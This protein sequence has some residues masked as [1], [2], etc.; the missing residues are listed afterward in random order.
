MWFARLIWA[1]ILTYIVLECS[2]IGTLKVMG[3]EVNNSS[4]HCGQSQERTVSSLP[5]KL[6]H[7]PV[8]LSLPYYPWSYYY[9]QVRNDPDM[10]PYLDQKMIPALEAPG[11][12]VYR[13]KQMAAAAMC[14]RL[15]LARSGREAD[16]A[17]DGLDP[18][19]TDLRVAFAIALSMEIAKSEQSSKS[20]RIAALRE[21]LEVV[22]ADYPVG[23]PKPF[24]FAAWDDTARLTAETKIEVQI[25]ALGGVP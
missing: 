6:T 10:G 12:P 1:A 7:L 15:A 22:R 8:R 2:S 17:F 13:L 3:V 23:I 5:L 19:E 25:E 16:M 21:L 9:Q 24:D 18:V 14:A 20:E 11:D 4:E